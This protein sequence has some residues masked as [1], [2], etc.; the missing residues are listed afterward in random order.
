MVFEIQLE[1]Q[2]ESQLK[3]RRSDESEELAIYFLA[4]QISF[5]LQSR[6]AVAE[7]MWREQRQ[8]PVEWYHGPLSV[9]MS[10]CSYHT[11]VRWI[12]SGLET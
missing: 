8:M 12:L 10:G 11:N 1:S 7:A 4:F 5:C 3:S 2:L 6:Q 9:F